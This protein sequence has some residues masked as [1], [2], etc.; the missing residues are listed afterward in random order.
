M[1]SAPKRSG[2]AFGTGHRMFMGNRLGCKSEDTPAVPALSAFHK[3]ISYHYGSDHSGSAAA[4][5]DGRQAM[6]TE[7][8]M[9]DVVAMVGGCRVDSLL[10]PNDT[11]RPKNADY[12]FRNDNVIA[13]L[14]TLKQVFTPEYYQQLNALAK[15]WISRRIILVFGMNKISFRRLPTVCQQGFDC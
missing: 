6:N 3:K 15:S 7:A 10:P 2:K 11:Q 12:I 8:V 4:T 14:K 1:W 13:E 9:N 5:F